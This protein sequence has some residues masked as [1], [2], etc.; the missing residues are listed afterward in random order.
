MFAK[1]ANDA[2]VAVSLVVVEL[3]NVA[4]DADTDDPPEP[5]PLLT[6]EAD[7]KVSDTKEAVEAY[8]ADSIE[9]VAI[10]TLKL[11]PLSFVNVIIEPAAEAVTNP[12][13]KYE[14]VEAYDADTDEPPEPNPLLTAEEEINVSLMNDA[15]LDVSLVV[16]ELANVAKDALVALIAIEAV[17][18]F[19]AFVAVS[20]NVLSLA[21]VANDALVDV[22]LVLLELANVAN[23]ALVTDSAI[24]AL[25]ACEAE[26]AVREN[27]SVTI[28]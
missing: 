11:V 23:E 13:P 6:A 2:L 28:S 14:A 15:V 21:K 25:T 3:A 20:A 7:I 22:S 16:L 18:A 27:V 10:I 17:I 9:P 24:S 12:S 4:N 26:V 19:I 1:V 5:N 8:D